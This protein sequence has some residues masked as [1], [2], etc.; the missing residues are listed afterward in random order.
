M[1]DEQ[2]LNHRLI[3]ETLQLIPDL[4]QLITQLKG[5]PQLVINKAFPDMIPALVP[6]GVP[7][8]PSYASDP[9]LEIPLMDSPD[10]LL[11]D[12]RETLLLIQRDGINARLQ[13]R[14][15]ALLEAVVIPTERPTFVLH[16]G[17]FT[18][19][20]GQ[21]AILNTFKPEIEE[22]ARRV[23]RIQARTNG[24]VRPEGTG[25][26]VAD[27]VVITNRHVAERF[28]IPGA[29]ANW[30]LMQG[31]QPTI[32]YADDPDSSLRN[33]FP[34]T[35]VLG[36]HPDPDIDLALLELSDA[37]VDSGGEITPLVISSTSP[38]NARGRRVY[39][40][41]YPLNDPFHDPVVIRTVFGDRF[42]LKRLQPGEILAVFEGSKL[43]NHDCSTLGGNSGSCVVDLE[44]NQV[45]GL[46]FQGLQ[47]EWNQAI[48]LWSLRDDPWLRAAGVQFD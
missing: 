37:P 3:D 5:D 24:R 42:G 41:G 22:T 45:L 1:D 19:S 23:G 28:A 34:I 11:Q 35:R 26:L 6:R 48:A 40:V 44:T 31:K 21:W 25:F 30:E 12:T 8:D 13:P 9:V 27:R 17:R 10:Q 32:D 36:I 47:G 39:V 38:G 29:S 4:D 15:R 46:H 33:P 14:Q 18:V 43:F 7:S 16:S 20:N 2:R